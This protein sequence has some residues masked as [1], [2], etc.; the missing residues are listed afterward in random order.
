MLSNSIHDF[1]IY[2]NSIN[3]VDFNKLQE[4]MLNI[5]K[6]DAK[7]LIT[8][9]LSD[10]VNKSFVNEFAFSC[11]K[12]NSLLSYFFDKLTMKSITH[13]YFIVINFV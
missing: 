11:F 13:I 6:N 2:D 7:R 10:F 3:M 8:T 4:D 5:I 9:D 1:E 12:I